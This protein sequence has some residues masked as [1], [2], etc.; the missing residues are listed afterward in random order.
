MLQPN[1]MDELFAGIS[2][3]EILSATQ[4][5][6]LN[7]GSSFPALDFSDIGDDVLLEASVSVGPL[8][9]VADAHY[10]DISDDELVAASACADAVVGSVAADDDFCGPVSRFRKPVSSDDMN[11]IV[12]EKFS[13]RTVEKSTWA[14][15]LFGQ[16]RAERNVKCL[17]DDR[18]VYMDVP[19]SLMNDD[20][21]NY[22]VPLFI[23]EVL[24]KDGTE[25][26][27]A[28]L[29]DLVLSLQK[30]LEV[31]G[32][33]VKFLSDDKYRNIRDTLDGVM[34]QRARQGIGMTKKQAQVR[35][36]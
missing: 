30:H 32:R 21:L 25:Y 19:F 35:Y 16:W 23:T 3:S 29:R 24:K 2:D 8:A 34:K 18:L 6:E 27:P 15:S 26:P 11:A 13:K 10:S 4:L 17:S 12:G 22:T 33:N 20:Q 9:A 28:T 31:V 1:F 7:V 14:V 5:V 36:C